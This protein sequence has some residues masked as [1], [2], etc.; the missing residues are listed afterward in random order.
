MTF[1]LGE[2]RWPD[3]KSGL[4]DNTGCR[5]EDLVAALEK[6]SHSLTQRGDVM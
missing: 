3:P 6:A 2:V 5:M 1:L 4:A